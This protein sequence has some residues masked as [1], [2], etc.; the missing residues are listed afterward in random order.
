M[1]IKNPIY[2]V[3]ID[4]DIRDTMYTIPNI[5][6]VK[7][8]T[9]ENK[10]EVLVKASKEDETEK[11]IKYF[12]RLH[13]DLLKHKKQFKKEQVIVTYSPNGINFNVKK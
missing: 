3:K 8:D 10:T 4:G 12:Y 2:Y 5:I 1:N 11:V 9:V 7:Y 13:E 6:G